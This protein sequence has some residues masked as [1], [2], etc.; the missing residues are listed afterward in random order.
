MLDKEFRFL[1]RRQNV[2]VATRRKPVDPYS[3]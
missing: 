2:L 1:P 3:L